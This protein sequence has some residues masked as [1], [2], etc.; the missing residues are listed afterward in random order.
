MNTY[1]ASLRRWRELLQ[2]DI[3]IVDDKLTGRLNA[4]RMAHI[5]DMIAQGLDSGKSPEFAIYLGH[6]AEHTRFPFNRIDAWR[7]ALDLLQSG[8]AGVI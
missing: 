4:Q 3:L 7:M 5:Q 6:L 1:S 8:K 2:R